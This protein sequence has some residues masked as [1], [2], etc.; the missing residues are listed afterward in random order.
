MTC[1]RQPLK[2]QLK[3]MRRFY[4]REEEFCRSSQ[5]L[6]PN[7]WCKAKIHILGELLFFHK[8]CFVYVHDYLYSGL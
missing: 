6:G 8:F 4:T 3:D 5:P 1:H 2:S 7:T